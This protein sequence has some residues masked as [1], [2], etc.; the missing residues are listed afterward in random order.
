MAKHSKQK[1][2]SK[3]ILWASVITC[4]VAVVSVAALLLIGN[5]GFSMFAMTKPESES[6]AVSTTT[7]VSTTVSESTTQT[8]TSPTTLPTTKPEQQKPSE[9]PADFSVP[10]EMKGVWL[11]PGKD[12]FTS[13]ND[14]SRIVKAQIDAAIKDMLGWKMNTVIVPLTMEGKALYPSEIYGFR[15]VADNNTANFDP[16]RYLID[17]ARAAKLHVYAVIDCRVG[18]N[19][20]WDPTVTKDAEKLVEAAGEAARRYKADGFMIDDYGYALGKTGSY[21]AYMEKAAG[22][23][24]EAYVQQCLYGAMQRTVQAIKQVDR[25]FYVGLLSGTVWAHKRVNQ[26]GSNTNNIY[27]DFTDGHA[28]TRT[29]LLKNTFDFVMVKSPYSTTHPSANFVNV[30]NW[31]SALCADKKIPLYMVHA[32]DKAGTNEKGWNTPEQLS[33]QL[34]SC[35]GVKAW[36]GSTYQSYTALKANRNGSV[37][38]LLKAYDGSILEEYISRTLSVTSP[39]STSLT[40]TESTISLRGSADPNF[41]LTMNGQSV[42]LSEHGYFAMDVKLNPGSNSFT[43]SHKGQTK[44]YLVTY[45]VIVIKSHSPSADIKVDGGS[46]LVLSM[47][48]RKNSNVYAMLNGKRISMKQAGL[49]SDED[50]E[51]NENSEFCKYTGEYTVPKGIIGKVHNLGNVTFYA[52]YSNLNEN[53]KGGAITINAL[54]EPPPPDQGEIELPNVLPDLKPI[55]PNTGGT[56]LKTGTVI[57]IKEDFAETF[58]GNTTDDYSRPINAYMPKGTTDVIVKKVYDSTTGHGYYLLE[59]GRR[60]YVDDVSTYIKN[61]KLSANKLKV[62]SSNVSNSHTVIKFKSD[63]RV[64]YNVQAL[65]Q[66][67]S[68]GSSA[69][70]QYRPEGGKL[71]AEYIDITFSYTTEALALPNISGSPLIKKAEWR[72]GGANES[73][74]RLYL[75]RV[76]GYFGFSAG[77]DNEGNLT[78]A[79]KNTPNVAKNSA[80]QPLKGTTIMLDPGHGGAD[81]GAD[82]EAKLVLQYGLTLKGKLEGLGATVIMTRS[83]NLDKYT[84][85]KMTERISMLRKK[86]PDLFISLHMDSGPASASGA[87][88]FYFYEYSYSLAKNIYDSVREVEKKH[89]IG[90]RADPLRWNTLYV[91]RTAAD[92]PTILLECGFLSSTANKELLVKPAYEEKFTQAIVDGIMNY[93]ET[94]SG[95]PSGSENST[96]VTTTVTGAQTTAA[97]P[98]QASTKLVLQSSAAMPVF[99]KRFM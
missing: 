96:T 48:A 12:Y 22:M 75:H 38:L 73:V 57:I 66:K 39:T 90:N 50:G 65:P 89:N 7:D 83:T 97:Q 88:A 23:G 76:G 36:K 54:P 44:T 30:L 17:K 29:W 24:F 6:S 51:T 55:N 4:I 8:T 70:P 28:D 26:L 82:I 56:T 5:G 69:Q 85:L 94:Y 9:Q 16:I 45:K 19:N 64:P 95:V 87:S 98:A 2:I 78:I 13:E 93:F 27:E 74:L 40:T 84:D 42:K 81:G 58:S 25:N 53:R 10:G 41:P 86:K 77:W 72:K 62:V 80:E 92:C 49:E 21:T 37:T 3:K 67:Y 47:V 43:F 32:A 63:W 46:S 60:V 52:S 61:G 33:R 15:A 35:Q 71:T 20:G 1:P 99:K 91:T 31:W 14:T 18:E 34:L 79:L 68:F 11:V 59:S